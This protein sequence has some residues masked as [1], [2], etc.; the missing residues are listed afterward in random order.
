MKSTEER[1]LTPLPH[2]VRSG[3]LNFVTKSKVWT[4]LAK[5]TPR[6][7]PRGVSGFGVPNI[8]KGSL[9]QA[10]IFVKSGIK[11]GYL[12]KNDGV[13]VAGITLP[14]DEGTKYPFDH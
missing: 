3:V 2:G 1:V 10:L 11:L 7:L 5:K 14:C 13:E 9:A 4:K 12:E 8:N 6:V